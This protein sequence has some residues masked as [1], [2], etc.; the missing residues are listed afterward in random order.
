MRHT[1]ERILI[2]GGGYAG[3]LAAARIARR[4]VPVTLVDA[5]V[6]LVE[7]I[8]LHQVLAGD[9]IVPVP[10]AK[11]FRKLPVDVVRTRVEGLDRARKRVVTTDGFLDYDRLIYA[12]G[13]TNDI[14]DPRKVRAAKKV[15]IVG[16]GLTGI[17]TAAELAERHPR[18]ELTLIDS[19]RLG[20]QLSDRAAS[21][22]REWLVSRGVAI[23]E[24]TRVETADAD[25]LLWCNAFR[26][27]G[28]AR[29]AG[30]HVNARGQIVV[31][32]QLRSSDPSIYAVGDAAAFRD[33]RMG[34]VSAMPMGAYAADAIT[35]HAKEPFR[36]AFGI[37]CISLG[38]TAGIIQMLHADDS[39]KDSFIGGRPAAWIKELICRFTVAAIKLE[40]KGIPYQWPKPNSSSIA[41]CSS[42]SRIA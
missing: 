4:G 27:S 32:E 24:Q 28:I 42:P 25:V 19:G 6:G 15:A 37:K 13:S 12:L 3:S 23:V 38:R 35:G 9:E 17:E 5:N 22:L 41:D 29:D 14:V 36:F 18:L 21:Y 26:V 31:D 20:A 7:R 8:R 30:L 1:H 33:V 10:F 34:C 16:A 2:L 11:L 39:P 40:A